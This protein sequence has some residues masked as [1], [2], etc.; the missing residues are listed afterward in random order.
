[1]I[2]QN[3]SLS[4]YEDLELSNQVPLIK[5]LEIQSY[6]TNSKKIDFVLNTQD[7][8]PFFETKLKILIKDFMTVYFSS[9]LISFSYFSSL[10]LL[11]VNLHF[12]G[13]F[14]NPTL[15]A[16]I[17]LGNVWINCLAINIIVGFNYGF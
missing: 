14:N 15:I 16:A 8:K 11:I 4:T 2:S 5:D 3:S 10:V 9:I 12:I 7:N 17:G 1:M 6:E 13:K